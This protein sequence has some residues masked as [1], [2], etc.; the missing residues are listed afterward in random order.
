MK[1]KYIN[2]QFGDTA[3]K[4]IEHANIILEEYA[5][6]GMQLTLRGLYYQ[7]VSRDLIANNMQEYNR[8]KTIVNDGR[9]EG[10]IDWAL[11]VDRTRNL[12]THEH[13]N[14]I[15]AAIAAAAKQMQIDMWRSQPHRVEVWIEKDAMVGT[16]APTCQEN[17]VPYFSCRGYNSQSEAWRASQRILKYQDNGFIPVILHLADHDPSGVNMSNDLV[18]RMKVFGCASEGRKLWFKRIALTMKQIEQV[19][20]PPNPAKMS[21]SRAKAY[22]EEFGYES[23]ELDALTPRYVHDLLVRH[24][25]QLR[26]KGQWQ[27]DAARCELMRARLHTLA[28][29]WKE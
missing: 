27:E 8:L 1:I 22:V 24:F 21:D 12:V 9:L 25:D 10:L 3:T 7:F 17:D 19:K 5:R 14:D 29:E 11:L 26:D 28:K 16:I 4:T 15:P 20:P 18:N 23:W 6:Q 13:V 2:R